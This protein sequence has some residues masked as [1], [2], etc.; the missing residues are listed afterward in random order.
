MLRLSER[1]NIIVP[2]YTLSEPDPMFSTSHFCPLYWNIK[3]AKFICLY[4]YWKH[5]EQNINE[6][7]VHLIC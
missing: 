3:H 1:K 4:V 6:V 7:K 5:Y 2:D